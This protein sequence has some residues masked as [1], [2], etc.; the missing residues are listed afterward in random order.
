MRSA[1]AAALMAPAVL[2]IA[3]TPA[4]GQALGAVFV[5]GMA[6]GLA[7]RLFSPHVQP[8][9]IFPAAIVVGGITQLVTAMMAKVSLL[10]SMVAG[11][12]PHF[13]MPMPVDYAAAACMG[14]A[15]GLGWAKSFL[16]HDEE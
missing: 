10:T 2:L 16:H 8:I 5:G 14:V 6:V 4:K 9:L 13:A 1:A 3:Q 15:I 7:G 12:L 11:D